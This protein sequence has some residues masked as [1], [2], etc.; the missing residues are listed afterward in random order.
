[1]P[2]SQGREQWTHEEVVAGARQSLL[3]ELAIDDSDLGRAYL[4]SPI[5]PRVRVGGVRGGLARFAV[6][7]VGRTGPG[8]RYGGFVDVS[9]EVVVHLPAEVPVRDGLSLP[10]QAAVALKL[11]PFVAEVAERG[12]AAVAAALLARR[13]PGVHEV[14]RRLRSHPPGHAGWTQLAAADVARA[15]RPDPPL[16]ADR[17]DIFQRIR[18]ACTYA[19]DRALLEGLVERNPGFVD[20]LQCFPLA[21]ALKRRVVAWLGPTNSGKTHRA[22]L[23]LAAAK[24]GM[25]LGPLRLLALEQ[26]DRLT[27]LGTPCS[28]VTGEERDAVSPTH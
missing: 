9:D 10:V 23:A 18:I 22:V 17:K 12:P 1:M 4:A 3:A 13:H 28:L 11:G 6:E 21:R 24:S 25:Y 8:V 5:G 19:V 15:F 27:E 26:R 2:T 7:A 14:S 16:L 20:Y